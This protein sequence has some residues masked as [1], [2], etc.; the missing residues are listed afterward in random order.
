M[1]YPMFRKPVFW[2]AFACVALGC[3]W[4][5]YSFFSRAFPIV[6]LSIS[7]DR[8]DALLSA[9]EQAERYGWKP[10]VY[11]QAATFTVDGDAE[12]FI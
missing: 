7:M 1:G 10:E 8:A 2:I 5:S 9:M 3:A 6:S 12:N 11:R 4:F